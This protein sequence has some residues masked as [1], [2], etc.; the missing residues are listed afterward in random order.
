MRRET[1]G[2]LAEDLPKTS[3]SELVYR[4]RQAAKN[5]Y[6]PYSKFQVGAAVWCDDGTIVVGCNVENASYGLTICAERNALFAVKAQGKTPIAL[7]V[8][9]PSAG[10]A[11]KEYKMPCGACRQVMA[12]FL[13]SSV[14][15]VVDG[16]GTYSIDDLLPEAFKL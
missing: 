9:C 8:T 10:D 3:H 13:D 16:V 5:A 14:E 11:P 15:I 4:A 7:A 1:T 12:E 2:T 6:C